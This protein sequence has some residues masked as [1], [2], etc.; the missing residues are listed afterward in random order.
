[1]DQLGK[2]ISSSSE[3]EQVPPPHSVKYPVVRRHLMC[4]MTWVERPADKVMQTQEAHLKKDDHLV[5]MPCR[6]DFAG[7]TTLL[8]H[9]VHPSDD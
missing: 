2:E 5:L 3:Q 9:P 8:S 6:V 1:M 4:Q 7:D